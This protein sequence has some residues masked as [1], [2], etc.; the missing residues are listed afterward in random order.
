MEG[1]AIVFF[2]PNSDFDVIYRKAK[3]LLVGRNLTTNAFSEAYI[4]QSFALGSL[5][6]IERGVSMIFESTNGKVSLPLAV[7]NDFLKRSKESKDDDIL[8]YS[9]YMGIDWILTK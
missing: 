6:G 5:L 3:E 1:A 7:V 2:N 9:G 8:A 4:M